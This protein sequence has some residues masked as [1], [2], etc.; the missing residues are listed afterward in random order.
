[1]PVCTPPPSLAKESMAAV[2]T[3][4]FGSTFSYFIR[5]NNDITICGLKEEVCSV[6]VVIDYYNA[7]ITRLLINQS[8]TVFDSI[9][10]SLIRMKNKK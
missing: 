2:S 7:I 10:A 1:M 6:K 4:V 5:S 8:N 3:I 9:P